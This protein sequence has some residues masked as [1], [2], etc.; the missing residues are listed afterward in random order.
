MKANIAKYHHNCKDSFSDYKLKKKIEGKQKK[1]VKLQTD[2]S[3]NL[4]SSSPRSLI[5]SSIPKC[6]I[7]NKIDELKNLHA[8]GALHSTKTKL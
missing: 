1:K 5:D 3:P 8:S 7:F 6:I 2:H 4:R